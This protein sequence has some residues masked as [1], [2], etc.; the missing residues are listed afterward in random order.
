M[1]YY[2]YR[3]LLLLLTT[4]S[5][6]AEFSKETCNVYALI[7]Q[8]LTITLEQRMLNIRDE[9]R[10]THNQTIVF[11]RTSGVVRMGR[12]MDVDA[13]GSLKLLDLG[14]SSAGSYKADVINGTG[15]R[16]NGWSGRVC[17][18]EKVPT[19]ALTFL[20]GSSGATAT[21]NCALQPRDVV[22]AW[23]RGGQPL[24]GETK[25]TLSVSLAKFKDDGGFSCSVSN[26]A[27]KAQ[28]NAVRLQCKSPPP[29]PPPPPPPAAAPAAAPPAATPVPIVYCFKATTVGAAVTG[30][31]SLILLLFIITVV[32]CYRRKKAPAPAPTPEHPEGLPMGLAPMCLKT[33]NGIPDYEIMLPSIDTPRPSPKPSPGPSHTDAGQGVNPSVA[34]A[35]QGLG[36]T[37]P[38]VKPGCSPVPKPRKNA[39]KAAK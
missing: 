26:G 23:T 27:S 1:V 3:L 19:P 29:L 14:F 24:K 35:Q 38:E 36:S 30:G 7:G 21:L 25:P 10:W 20:C 12:E 9:L 33:D 39:P 17:V 2:V 6:V 11:S 13:V 16:V 5:I 32:A 8:N 28:S 15:A 4:S 34:K 31:S 18:V 37:S 22:F